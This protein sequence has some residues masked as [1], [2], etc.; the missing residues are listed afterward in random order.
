MLNAKMKQ[1]KEQ[2]DLRLAE[3][4]RV[5]M[6]GGQHTVRVGFAYHQNKEVTQ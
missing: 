6:S 5:Q 2:H 3:Y 1:A 4:F